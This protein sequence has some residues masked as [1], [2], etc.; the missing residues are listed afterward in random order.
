MC[1][2]KYLT[3]LEGVDPMKKITTAHHNKVRS[4]RS[5]P[6]TM[7]ARTSQGL[8]EKRDTHFPSRLV[9]RA[10]CT[11]TSR[12]KRRPNGFSQCSGACVANGVVHKEKCCDGAIHLV[13][14]H[15]NSAAITTPKQYQVLPDFLPNGLGTHRSKGTEDGRV[16]GCPVLSCLVSPSPVVSQH[17]LLLSQQAVPGIQSA[18]LEPNVNFRCRVPH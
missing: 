9:V 14:L 11:T 13:I 3:H 2:P 1:I 12:H 7:H 17:V 5:T 8:T 10:I 18:V 6:F 4:R 15:K 16:K